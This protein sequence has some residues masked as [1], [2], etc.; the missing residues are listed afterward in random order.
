MAQV[1]HRGREPRTLPADLYTRSSA[2]CHCWLA[3]PRKRRHEH[4]TLAGVQRARGRTTAGDARQGA[5]HAGVVRCG[6]A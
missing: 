4:P 1:I 6:S 3:T 2:S 5:P